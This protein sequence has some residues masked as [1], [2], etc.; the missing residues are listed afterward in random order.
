MT[1]HTCTEGKLESKEGL[2]FKY[3]TVKL[4]NKIK[5]ICQ[6]GEITTYFY[7]N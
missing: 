7:A 1:Q 5:K 3:N 6:M 4:K 2:G